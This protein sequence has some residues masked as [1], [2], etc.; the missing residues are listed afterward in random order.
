MLVTITEFSRLARDDNGN[1]V[2]LGEGRLACQARTS[3]G[4]FS[5]LSSATKIIRVATDTSIQ[6]DIAGGSV[7]TSDE[8]MPGP[9]VEYFTVRGGETINIALA[10]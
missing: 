10:A 7:S 9:L 4:A 6:I 5:P 3:A 8:L 2:P 1:L